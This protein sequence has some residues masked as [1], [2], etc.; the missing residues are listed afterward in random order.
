MRM[1]LCNEKRWRLVSLYVKH[2]LSFRTYRHERLS[3]LANKEDIQISARR[4]RDLID[5]W[6][7]TGSV[8]NRSSPNKG[9]SHTRISEQDMEQK[10]LNIL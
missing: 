4:A 10:Y 7:Q 3:R 5:K 6:L 1:R 9:L 8:V 2:D